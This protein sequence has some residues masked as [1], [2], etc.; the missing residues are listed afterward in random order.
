MKYDPNIHHRRSI[1]LKDYD[2]SQ[3]GAYFVTI[4]T[5]NRSH[6]FGEIVNGMMKVNDTGFVAQIEW[7]KLSFRFSGISI[8]NFVVMPDHMHAIIV[9][10]GAKPEKTHSSDSPSFASPVQ[11]DEKPHPLGTIISSYKSTVARLINGL[12]HT[13]GAP[14][15]L[16]NYY[17]HIIRSEKEFE[18]IR[19]YI[20]DNPRRWGEDLVNHASTA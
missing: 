12:R 17:E 4:V 18:N 13:P 9:L 11:V 15:W 2:Y 6:L 16:R 8:D 1:R 19:S 10:V 20:E 3:S 7:K 14:V 5:Y